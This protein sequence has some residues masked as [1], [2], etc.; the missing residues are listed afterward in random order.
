MTNNIDNTSLRKI[1]RI[2]GLLYL[3]IIVSG[4]FSEMFV[5]S[6]LIVPGDAT[7]TANNILASESLFRIG[8]ASDLIMVMCDIGV[9]LAFYVLLKPVNKGLA[10]LAAFFRLVQAAILGF[11]SLNHFAALLLLS[12]ADYLT[13]F[14]TDQLHALV[15]LFLKMHTH[16]YLISGV[17]FSLSLFVLGYLFMKSDYFPKILGVFLVFATF[18]YLLDSFTNFLLP[19]YAAITE[20][21]VVASAVIAELSLCLWLLFK[22]VREPKKKS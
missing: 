3:I 18:G 7:A 1:A 2:A 12:G 8:F 15:M 22:G 19:N 6:N 10:L 17:F 20:W 13:V 9:A 11:N 4:I 16:G 14:E 5:R 21:F